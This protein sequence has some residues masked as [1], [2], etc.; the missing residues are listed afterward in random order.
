VEERSGAVPVTA[1][2]Q[3]AWREQTPAGQFR[4][5]FGIR[6]VVDQSSVQSHIDAIQGVYR[7]RFGRELTPD[8]LAAVRRGGELRSVATSAA[9]PV[10]VSAYELAAEMGWDVLVRGRSTGVAARLNGEWSGD[11]DVI[12]SVLAGEAERERL[13]SEAGRAW[14]GEPGDP[15]RGVARST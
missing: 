10:P 1:A 15:R 14:R 2:E 5:R 7:S 3:R 12:G 9:R 4:Q 6:E 8:E 11:P 13:A